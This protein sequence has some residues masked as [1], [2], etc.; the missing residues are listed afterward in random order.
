M[1]SKGHQI[2]HTTHSGH[3]VK[4]LAFNQLR[5]TQFNSNKQKE[6]VK[7]DAQAL[8]YPSLNEIN[9]IAFGDTNAE[10]HDELYGHLELK[11]QLLYF[12]KENP[13]RQYKRVRR[14]GEITIKDIISLVKYIRHQIH[15]PKNKQNIVYTPEE[16]KQSIE[17]MKIFLIAL[18]DSNQ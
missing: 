18:N 3:I 10:Y 14:N 6:V 16:L 13:K 5:L 4:Q 1:A 12:E 15:H 9:Y 8:P 2:L 11:K 7:V 17:E